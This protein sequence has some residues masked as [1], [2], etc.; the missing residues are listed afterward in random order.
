MNIPVFRPF[1]DSEAVELVAKQL[2]QGYISGNFGAALTALEELFS[3][4]HSN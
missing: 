1:I 4:L 2:E 3:H